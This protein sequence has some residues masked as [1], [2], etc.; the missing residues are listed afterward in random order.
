MII[1]SH[2][3]AKAP[4][5]VAYLT[6]PAALTAL[7]DKLRTAVVH[8]GENVGAFIRPESVWIRQLPVDPEDHAL[9]QVVLLAEWSPDPASGVELRGGAHDGEIINLH[10][11]QDGRPPITVRLPD[12]TAAPF[13]VTLLSEPLSLSQTS[14]YNL[15]GIDSSADRWIYTAS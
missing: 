11:G 1:T 10:R 4:I 14:A 8:E 6:V 13:E 7:R 5:D 2:V 9:N 3:R 12:T 15:A